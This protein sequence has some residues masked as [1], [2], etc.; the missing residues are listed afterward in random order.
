MT[1]TGSPLLFRNLRDGTFQDVA[2]DVGLALDS[3]ATMAAIGDFNKDGY[4]DLFF[5]RADA[6]GIFATSDGRGRYVTAASPRRDD[7]R[8]RGAVPR[9]R[10]RRPARSL[11]AHGARD[12]A[13]CAISAASGRTSPRAPW[14]QPLIAALDGRPRHSPPA[15][16]TATAAPTSSRAGHPGLTVWRANG[17]GTSRAHLRVRLTS[18]V[19]NR[20]AV[21]AK[22]EM[23]AG[24]LR[25]QLET[26]ARHAA[27][28]R[29][30]TCSSASAIAPAPTWCA[31]C[32]RPASCRPRPARRARRAAG[33]RAPSLAR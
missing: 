1:A 9:L 20:S 33:R 8:A 30:R 19:S 7:G 16:S 3:G 6:A 11:R 23:R 24:S 18:R 28:R 27:R 2:G 5:P 32:G 10:Q 17:G 29:R 31:C 15:I 26:Y 22:I 25:Q 21:G 13:C 4:Q 12:R 14:T